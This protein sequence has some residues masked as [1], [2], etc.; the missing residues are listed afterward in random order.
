[1]NMMGHRRLIFGDGSNK[2]RKEHKHRK[3]EVAIPTE[4]FCFL[5]LWQRAQRDFHLKESAGV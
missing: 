4:Y 2:Q 5:T 1:M 3:P